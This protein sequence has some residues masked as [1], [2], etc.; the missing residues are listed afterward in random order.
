MIAVGFIKKESLDPSPEG[1][2]NADTPFNDAVNEAESLSFKEISGYGHI[3]R[4]RHAPAN[5]KKNEKG[6]TE[7][8]TFCGFHEKKGADAEA[9][10]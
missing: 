10:A 5:P 1:P 7:D 4:G 3:K 2:G 6:I 8:F 9:E